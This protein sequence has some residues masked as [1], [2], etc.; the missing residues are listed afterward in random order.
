MKIRAL[1][2]KV[3]K[4]DVIKAVYLG[5]VRDLAAEAGYF[6]AVVTYRHKMDG[7]GGGYEFYLLRALGLDRPWLR[8]KSE[9]D[10]DSETANA[11]FAKY[12]SKVEWP[13]KS[14]T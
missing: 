7:T 2:T 14:T 13:E 8:V 6:A 12:E 5:W 10:L 11:L 1:P 3:D 9:W 4:A